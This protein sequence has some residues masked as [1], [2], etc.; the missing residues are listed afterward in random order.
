MAGS[1]LHA[2]NTRFILSRYDGRRLPGRHAP[3]DAPRGGRGAAQG[4]AR[5]RRSASQYR[6]ERAARRSPTLRLPAAASIHGVA[7]RVRGAAARPEVNTPAQKDKAAFRN[8]REAA[9]A[10][11]LLTRVEQLRLLSRVEEAGLLSLGAFR[12]RRAGAAGLAR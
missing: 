9:P 2:L 3:A 8:A 5:D 12:A 11:K 6:C 1:N 4:D 7:E 10:P